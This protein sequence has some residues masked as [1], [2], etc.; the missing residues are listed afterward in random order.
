MLAG[1]AR[2]I[3]RQGKA[4]VSKSNMAKLSNAA[5]STSSPL[6]FRLTLT[7]APFKALPRTCAA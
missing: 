2:A 3:V 1:P 7:L 6:F 4:A 5:K